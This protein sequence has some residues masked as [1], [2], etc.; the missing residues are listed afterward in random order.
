MVVK[1]FLCHLE[2]TMDV[3]PMR[4]ITISSVALSAGS[5]LQLTHIYLFFRL[6]FWNQATNQPCN[7]RWWQLPCPTVFQLCITSPIP[8]GMSNPSLKGH[9]K[10][11]LGKLLWTTLSR[12][13]WYVLIR[14][15]WSFWFL[16]FKRLCCEHWS[17]ILQHSKYEK[18]Y[19]V[20]YLVNCTVHNVL[21][22]RY[23]ILGQGQLENC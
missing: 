12:I 15:V 20:L 3:I 13:I 6:M 7:P 8:P 19:S 4:W 16:I 2:D 22:F 14:G 21:I 18:S 17:V 1:T 23:E 9:K 5:P 11:K 10:E